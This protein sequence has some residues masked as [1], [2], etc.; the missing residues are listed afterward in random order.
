MGRRL[1][2]ALT[3]LLPLALF[4]ALALTTASQAAPIAEPEPGAEADPSGRTVFIC[5]IRTDG[6]M[7]CV[8]IQGELDVCA[9]LPAGVI[10]RSYLAD[11]EQQPSV[12][13]P[14]AEDIDEAIK[15]TTSGDQGTIADV[16][17]TYGPG[18][19]TL[20][21]I[22]AEPEDEFI[23]PAERFEIGG[24]YKGDFTTTWQDCA[25]LP[26]GQE[27]TVF[28]GGFFSGSGAKLASQEMLDAGRNLQILIAVN[29]EDEQIDPQPATAP[30]TPGDSPEDPSVPD[31]GPG[32]GTGGD[33]GG[34]GDPAPPPPLP[35][36]PPPTG[37]G[38]DEFIVPN[39]L[40][41]TL[42]AATTEIT[43]EGYVVGTVTFQSADAA[44]PGGLFIGSAHAQV[45]PTV[46]EQRPNGG[47][48]RPKGDSVDLVLSGP[49]IDIP[50]PSSLALL[51]LGL[52][53]LAMLLWVR[54]PRT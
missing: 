3:S 5:D 9:R 26:A 7:T 23:E 30:A 47:T 14:T 50:E 31:G 53:L 18:E 36:L 2:R 22:P 12:V 38:G 25:P 37:G 54:R 27:L 45:E 1:R 15:G 21:I 39:V 51:I 52:A 4:A 46:V 11:P 17:E 20:D 41:L 6:T 43:G 35:P 29:T 40:G 34:P 28:P 33:G 24:I 16:Q 49:P 48:V 13:V 10:R 32:D 44:P 19:G 8:T 42:P